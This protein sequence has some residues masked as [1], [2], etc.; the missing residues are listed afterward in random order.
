MLIFSSAALR[1]ALLFGHSRLASRKFTSSEK[2]AVCGWRNRSQ[3]RIV[4]ASGLGVMGPK[5]RVDGTEVVPVVG[6]VPVVGGVTGPVTGP[7]T[8][9]V[10]GATTG[11]IT[12][13]PATPKRARYQTIC[14]G[15]SDADHDGADNIISKA[16]NKCRR[17]L[18]MIGVVS[19]SDAEFIP[20]GTESYWGLRV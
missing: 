1:I 13:P 19:L 5:P 18:D 2:L 7:G 8:D 20:G 10:T 9:V 15:V 17:M 12:A 6:I 11:G 3:R 4:S 14:A 16:G